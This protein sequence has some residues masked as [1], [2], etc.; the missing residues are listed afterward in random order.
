MGVISNLL[1]TAYSQDAEFIE[2]HGMKNTDTLIK[3]G[4]IG[5]SEELE[6]DDGAKYFTQFMQRYNTPS[7]KSQANKRV[8]QMKRRRKEAVDVG[9]GDSSYHGRGYWVN[10]DGEVEFV[11]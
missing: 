4:M 10:E 1:L 6:I 11:R 2:E 5:E 7:S 8:V 3:T 9:T